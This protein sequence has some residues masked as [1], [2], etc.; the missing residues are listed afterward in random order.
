MQEHSHSFCHNDSITR[1]ILIDEAVR[2]SL[3][4]I[5]Y[6][7]STWLV[8]WLKILHM[9]LRGLAQLLVGWNYLLYFWV[10]K[11]EA[12]G[13]LDHLTR[14]LFDAYGA[15]M[16]NSSLMCPRLTGHLDLFSVRAYV[17]MRA[18]AHH[19]FVATP[20]QLFYRLLAARALQ[21]LMIAHSRDAYLSGRFSCLLFNL[22]L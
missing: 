13:G 16:A 2:L 9:N 20:L 3:L 6:S 5:R 17:A 7:Y 4:R 8:C 14:P 11:L 19:A 10:R 15:S 18:M 22:M 12:L 21:A 1:G